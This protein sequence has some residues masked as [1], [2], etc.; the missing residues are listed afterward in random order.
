[1]KNQINQLHKEGYAEMQAHQAIKLITKLIEERYPRLS[2]LTKSRLIT[3]CLIEVKQ[4]RNRS[5]LN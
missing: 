3:Q 1:M 2:A 4:E 5:C